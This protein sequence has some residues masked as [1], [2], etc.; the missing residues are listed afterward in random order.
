MKSLVSRVAAEHPESIAISLLFSFANPRNELAIAEALEPLKIPLSISHQILPEF[1]EYERTSTV[2]VNAYLQPVMQRYLEN[3]RPLQRKAARGSG[4]AGGARFSATLRSSVRTGL[5]PRATPS[6]FRHAIDWRH[7]ALPPLPRI[8]SAP[9]SPALPE[10]W[11]VPPPAPV[12]VA[13][14]ASSPSTWEAPPPMS[15]WLTAP[16]PP[17]TMLEVAGLPISVPM[18]DIHTV[19][20]GGGSLARFDAA[21]VLR[22]GPESA[23]ADP[24]PSVTATARNPRSLTPISYWAACSQSIF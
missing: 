5:Q 13:S 10:A 16:L 22:V 12:A 19:G 20:A 17:P 8:Q 24:D 7:Y 14:R 2:A 21:G 9:S 4:S 23:G 15:P 6:H 3:L 18:L 11:S 1:R